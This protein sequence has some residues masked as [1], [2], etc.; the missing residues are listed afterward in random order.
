MHAEKIRTPPAVHVL[1]YV[2]LGIVLLYALSVRCGRPELDQ[3]SGTAGDRSHLLDQ[4][5]NPNTASWSEL[6]DLPG[7]GE[8]LAK[9]IIAYRLEQQ[10]DSPETSRPVYACLD[11]LQAIKGIG[12]KKLEQISEYVIFS[13]P[14]ER[15]LD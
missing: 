9:R 7:I 15:P 6:A 5:I 14:V 12:P 10:G 3:A 13:P 8:T 1:C 4:R 11:D 2:L